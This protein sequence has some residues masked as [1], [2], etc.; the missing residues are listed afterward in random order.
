MEPAEPHHII[1]KGSSGCDCE[2]NIIYLCRKCHTMCH[3]N[4]MEW[5]KKHNLEQVWEKAKKHRREVWQR[6]NEQKK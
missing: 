2:E 5:V 4:G 1:P 6:R 3:S